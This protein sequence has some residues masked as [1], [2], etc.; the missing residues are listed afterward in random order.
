MK[1]IPRLA[2]LSCLLPVALLAAVYALR[3]DEAPT[4]TPPASGTSVSPPRRM[5]I[6]C[7]FP[8]WAST[9]GRVPYDRLDQIYYA[10][11]RPTPAGGF[12]PLR[13]PALLKDLV[14]RAHAAGV[15]VSIAVGGALDHVA[16]AF[17]T[18]A[19]D[20]GLRAT[21]IRNLLAFAEDYD[22]DGIDID[23]E[24]PVAGVSDRHCG[25]LMQELS[26]VLRPR[27]KLLSMAVPGDSRK[28]DYPATV[29][30]VID[31]LN[32]MVYDR[33]RP[34]HATFDYARASI[35]YWTGR[36]CPA[37]KIMLG[38]PFYSR[39][40]T[41]GPL[42]YRELRRLG[43]DADADVFTTSDKHVH[44]YNGRATLRA[45][46]ALAREHAVRGIMIWEIQQ[47]TLGEDSL[48]RA[49]RE[50]IDTPSA[51]EPATAGPGTDAA[52][53]PAS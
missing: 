43:A 9:A 13:N 51:P 39:S 5:E 21:F 35:Q 18:I 28:P 32:V 29:F 2:S 22:L 42:A 16:P 15:K 30:P 20:P 52:A 7:Y 17:A 40:A 8:S 26:A 34:H 44:G 50:A 24:Y 33:G 19:A 49:L 37:G 38:V 36:G 47:D 46:V 11:L 10:F 6:S 25:L 14:R 53:K 12:E 23:W 48:L 3:A 41:A 4:T 27:G 31:C 1:I 45:K